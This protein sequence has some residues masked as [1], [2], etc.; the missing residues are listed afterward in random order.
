MAIGEWVPS[1]RK[2]ISLEKLRQYVEFAST[3]NLD[4]IKASLPLTNIKTDKTLMKHP[5]AD[6]VLANDLADDELVGLVRFFTLAEVQLPEWDGGRQSPVIYLVKILKQR[7]AFDAE[8]RK[9]IKANT[10]NRYLPN[11]AAL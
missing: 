8:L 9:W 2:E 7:S 4:D 5:V 6:W 10:D 1:E 3:L 11:G